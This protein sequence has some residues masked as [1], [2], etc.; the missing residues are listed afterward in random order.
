VRGE[1]LRLPY[2]ASTAIVA[3]GLLVPGMLVELD[4][5][6]VRGAARAPSPR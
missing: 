6:A 1:L 2:P 5:V 4:A 3:G